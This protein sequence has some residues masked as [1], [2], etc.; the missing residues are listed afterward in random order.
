MDDDITNKCDFTDNKEM[1]MN[2]VG[3]ISNGL[4]D[5][6]LKKLVGMSHA[7]KKPRV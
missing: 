3:D 5:V 7:N 4:N 6:Q 1:S 2:M